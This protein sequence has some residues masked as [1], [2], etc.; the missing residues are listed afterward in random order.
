M[1]EQEIKRLNRVEKEIKKEAEEMGLSTREILFQIVSSR[2]MI[3]A[4]AYHFPTNYS[5][6]S[7]G[8]DYDR[9]RTIYEHKGVG[10]PYEVVWNFNPPKAFLVETNSVAL[11][12]L[13]IAHVYGHVDFNIENKLLRHA[14]DSIDLAREARSAEKRFKAYERKYGFEKVE[15][16]IEAA[17]SLIDQQDPDLLSE[18]KSDNEIR[19]NLIKMKT[20]RI[21]DLQ[22]QEFHKD[23]STEIKKLK[24]E[25]QELKSKNP[26]KPRY[27]VLQFI[28]ENSSKIKG[29]QEDILSVIANQ[30]HFLAHQRRTKVVN[31]GWATFVHSHIMRRL[32]K[33]GVIT[34][35]EHQEF[36]KHNAGITR[37]GRVKI[38]PYHLGLSLY[39]DIVYRWSRGMHGRGFL[40]DHNPYK[41]SEW[42]GN[43]D[44]EKGLKKALQ[45]RKNY[46]DRM[47]VE[48]FFNA[49]FIRDNQLYIWGTREDPRTGEIKYV[50]TE[51]D[52]EVIRRILLRSYSLYGTPIIKVT[53][54][55]YSG[56]GELYLKHEF[57]GF[58]IN[59]EHEAG[60]LENIY[61]LWGRPV[62]LET[63]EFIRKKDKVVGSRRVLHSFDGTE[64]KI[65]KD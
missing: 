9:I 36:S 32:A 60:A 10:I 54:S 15:K 26:P 16:T 21:I 33:R 49:D 41:F 39:E 42:D 19:K 37:A 44:Q 14:G 1:N 48:H 35:N 30:W 43:V 2:K 8:R 64:H 51:D 7:F 3:E 22:R 53:D 38:N 27:D 28:L 65:K 40:E 62:H 23:N 12:I 58:E 52:P 20:D 6:W 45:V 29:W 13:V 50:I 18:K 57:S 34:P 24:K 17:K 63:V 55:N 31:E 46:T 4:M 11:N 61:Y 56:N 25:I 47:A 59:L 5:H